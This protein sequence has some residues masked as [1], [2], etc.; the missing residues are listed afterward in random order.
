MDPLMIVGVTDRTNF[1]ARIPEYSVF[2]SA[3]ESV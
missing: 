3:R 1:A 2:Y